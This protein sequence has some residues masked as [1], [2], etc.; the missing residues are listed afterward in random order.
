MKSQRGWMAT[1]RQCLS[2]TT[3]LCTYEL[4]K[5][6]TAC[7]PHAD[8][9]SVLREKCTLGA[10]G[11]RRRGAASTPQPRLSAT[12]THCIGVSTTL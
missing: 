12:D 7:T 4:P 11:G 10:G 8:G 3:R 5:T 6:V 1:K 2:D 9:I